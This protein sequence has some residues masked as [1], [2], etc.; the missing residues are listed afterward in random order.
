MQELPACGRHLQQGAGQC[1]L[2]QRYRYK[3]I[4]RALLFLLESDGEVPRA[5]DWTSSE[6]Q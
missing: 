1:Y 2:G 5:E 3:P 6:V 4:P